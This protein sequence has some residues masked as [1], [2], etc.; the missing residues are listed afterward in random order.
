MKQANDLHLAFPLIDL[1][2]VSAPEEIRR[3][4]DFCRRLGADT[5]QL[6]LEQVAADNPFPSDRE[7][8]ILREKYLKITRPLKAAGFRLALDLPT[9]LHGYE[10]AEHP[11]DRMKDIDGRDLES[12]CPLDPNWQDYICRLFAGFADTG[13]DWLWPDD[14]FRMDNHGSRHACYC[15]RHVQEFGRRYKHRLTRQELSGI[16]QKPLPLSQTAE[17]IKSAVANRKSENL[18]PRIV[19]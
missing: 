2:W 5:I 6:C 19:K 1:G 11:F 9:L 4:T 15:G 14:D 12:P 16:L 3:L 17:K 13:F 18:F 7:L 8:K 10:R